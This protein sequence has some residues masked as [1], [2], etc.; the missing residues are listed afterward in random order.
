MELELFNYS[1]PEKYI[2]QKPLPKRDESKLL[3]LNRMS[4]GI[5]HDIFLNLPNY[6]DNKDILVIN[7]SKVVKCRLF[8]KKESTGAKIECFVLNKIGERYKNDTRY[9]PNSKANTRSRNKDINDVKDNRYMVLIK[10]SKRLKISDKVFIGNYYFT[11][12]S[13]LDYGK[14]IVEFNTSPEVLFKKYGKMPIPPYIK[15]ND[16]DESYYQTIYAKNGES[17][18]APTAGLHFTAE[19]INKLK[20][21]GVAFAKVR[22]DIGLDTFRPIRE[23]KIEKHKMHS[24]YYYISKSEAEKINKVKENGG[25]IIAVGTTST[26]VL[27]SVISKYG[28]LK[29]DQGLTDLFIYPGYKFKIV[30]GIITNFHLPKSSLLVMVSAFAGRESILNAYKEAKKNGYRFYSFGDSML[31]K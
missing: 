28:R 8:G 24:E 4:G 21:N 3:I 16:I 2:A 31:V 17:A 7:E 15:S 5:K 9:V 25:R 10:P 14:A 12:K 11:V 29:E 22:L 1:L 27:E 18:A 19:L 23:E 20:D 26:R 13:K 30:D 6:I